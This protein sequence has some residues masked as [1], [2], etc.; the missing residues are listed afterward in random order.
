MPNFNRFTNPLHDERDQEFYDRQDAAAEEKADIARQDYPPLPEVKP[1]QV[2]LITAG[3][4]KQM[5]ECSE[6]ARD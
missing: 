6:T 5:T 1:V 3:E 4:L 2:R